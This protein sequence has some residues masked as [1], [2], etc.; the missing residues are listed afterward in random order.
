MPSAPGAAGG[1]PSPRQYGWY[2]RRLP[3]L[4]PLP[5]GSSG[6]QRVGTGGPVLAA[7]VRSPSLPQSRAYVVASRVPRQGTAI[8]E[9]V[10]PSPL[11][12]RTERRTEPFVVVGP[13]LGPLTKLPR[14]L[15]PWV[16]R[17]DAWRSGLVYRSLPAFPRVRINVAGGV[18]LPWVIRGDYIRGG[19]V[20][21]DE[22]FLKTPPPPTPGMIRNPLVFRWDHRSP[23]R[24]FW[25]WMPYAPP[26]AV[27]EGRT[28]IAWK[29]ET[30][31]IL[32]N[33]ES[34]GL[35]WEPDV[36]N[37]LTKH[38]GETRQYAMDFSQLPELTNGSL[39]G[40]SS[41]TSNGLTLGA[42]NVALSNPAVDSSGK[43]ATVWISSGQSGASYQIV[44]TVTVAGGTVLE[45][46]GYL[47]VEDE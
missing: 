19:L 47:L 39:A 25:E 34:R 13:R 21:R 9:R 23:A 20:Y 36:T 42:N 24:I 32:W 46:F 18:L 43:K 30:R 11:I 40:V 16:Y 44:F 29:S 3:A 37:F 27:L 31:G 4:S 10:V 38:S 5:G 14:P 12:I 1:V 17:A 22:P 33:A 41:V 35:T 26:S 15:L 2:K 28:W 45:E 6:T 7:V 8:L